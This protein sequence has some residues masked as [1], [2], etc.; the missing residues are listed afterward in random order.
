MLCALAATGTRC[1]LNALKCAFVFH[2][3]KEGNQCQWQNKKN[4]LNFILELSEVITGL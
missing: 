4:K 1:I 2:N 3:V